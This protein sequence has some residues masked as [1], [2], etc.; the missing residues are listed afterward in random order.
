MK[1]WLKAWI[2]NWLKADAIPGELEILE[3][4]KISIVTAVKVVGI[5]HLQCTVKG[6]DEV[7]LVSL[8]QARDER[9]WKEL[10]KELG[11]INKKAVWEDGS[12]ATDW[13]PS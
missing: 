4:G 1:K 7:R 3:D 13:L 2:Q 10:Y 9:R 12:P 8:A 5:F 11:G 6:T